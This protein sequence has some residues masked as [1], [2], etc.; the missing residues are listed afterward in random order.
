MISLCI[1]A[2]MYQYNWTSYWIE[3]NKNRVQ[4]TL[5]VQ[6]EVAWL[7]GGRAEKAKGSYILPA[8]VLFTAYYMVECS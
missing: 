7:M 4:D 6:C 1:L 5:Y 3:I 2:Q 8:P